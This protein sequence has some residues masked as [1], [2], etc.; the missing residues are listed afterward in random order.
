MIPVPNQAGV[1]EAIRSFLGAVLPSGVPAVI[2]QQNRIPEIYD[3]DFVMMAL[4][5]TT[6]LA[7]NLNLNAD[8]RFIGSITDD[9]M[10]VTEIDYGIILPGATVYGIDVSPFT[11]ILE[12]TSGTPPGGVGTYKLS[13]P[14]AIG[15]EVL[16]SGAFLI[17]QP[18]ELVCQLDFHSSDISNAGDMAQTVSTL[19]RDDY[20]TT[21]FANQAPQYGVTPLYCDDPKQVPF[22]NDQQQYEYR[23]S[24]DV[25]V[26]ANMVVSV[27]QQ[28]AEAAIV[29]L[30]NVDATFPP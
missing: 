5:R 13:A 16:A 10:T 2:G 28:Y 9:V 21:Q 6:R 11:T 17:T 23:W 20:G 24:L 3:A 19:F 29:G 30:I 12:Q 18:T 1:Y 26:Q 25:R 4:I 27:P 8:V 15:S 7:T 14:Q 22:L